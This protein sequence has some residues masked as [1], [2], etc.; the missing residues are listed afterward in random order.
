ML[1]IDKNAFYSLYK[2]RAEYIDK[3]AVI[4]A[5]FKKLVNRGRYDFTSKR[6][7]QAIYRFRNRVTI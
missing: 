4:R 2:S 5:L 1:R 3:E 7:K 6:S